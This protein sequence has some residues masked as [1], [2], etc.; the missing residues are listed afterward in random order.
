MTVDFNILDLLPSP[1]ALTTLDYDFNELKSFEEH[2]L[3]SCPENSQTHEKLNNKVE[4]KKVHFY[5][6]DEFPVIK[7]YLTDVVR[8]L[9]NKTYGYE[10]EFIINTSWLTKM[11]PNTEGS[12]H[13][14]NGHPFSCCLYFD[15]YSDQSGTFNVRSPLPSKTKLDLISNNQD[16]RNW[17]KLEICPQKNQLLIFPSYLEHRIGVNRSEKN[18]YSLAFNIFPM[19]FNYTDSHVDIKRIAKQFANELND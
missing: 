2:A 1:L 7:K 12:W 19:S 4:I 13:H 10:E 16:Q 18:R 14:H 11:F 3:C 9:L 6:L 5:V 15:E 17:T 8:E